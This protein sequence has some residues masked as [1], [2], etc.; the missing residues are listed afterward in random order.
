M[1]DYRK[2]LKKLLDHTGSDT[3]SLSQSAVAIKIILKL[4]KRINQDENEEKT[5]ND[6]DLQLTDSNKPDKAT[7][8][9]QLSNDELTDVQAK[10]LQQSSE[11][12]STSNLANLPTKY[13]VEREL[14]GA[15]VQNATTKEQ[16]AYYPENVIHRL[17]WQDGD[18][19]ELDFDH[20]AQGRPAIVKLIAK[21]RPQRIVEF[22]F[23]KVE[24]DP[25]SLSYY[26]RESTSGQLLSVANPSVDEYTIS[27]DVAEG[28]HIHEGSLIDLVW[29]DNDP[30]FVRI[31][32]KHQEGRISDFSKPKPASYYKKSK[33]KDSNEGNNG[34]TPT[35]DFDLSGR[36]VAIIGAGYRRDFYGQMVLA[37]N[38]HYKIVEGHHNQNNTNDFY[39]HQLDGQSY[40]IIA[41]NMIDHESVA[42]IQAALKK[43]KIS[44]AY[45]TNDGVQSMEQALYRA[46][47]GLPSYE[48]GSDQTEYPL[49]KANP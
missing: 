32:W 10:T 43:H 27:K 28:M 35:I 25:S 23:G 24:F 2:D 9:L 12:A 8:T 13:I 36:S 6:Q 48:S 11:D 31:R 49:L 3:R 4:A 14:Y 41:L 29:Y 1:Y 21:H 42:G 20:Q 19:V 39:D 26:V 38:G 22:Q 15:S 37:H 18:E 34:F 44:F 17:N 40:A 16:V 30:N 47:K 45:S 7:E 33:D 46:Y 5:A